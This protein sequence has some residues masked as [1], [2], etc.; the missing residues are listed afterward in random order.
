MKGGKGIKPDFRNCLETVCGLFDQSWLRKVSFSVFTITQKIFLQDIG[1]HKPA[2]PEGVQ[3]HSHDIQDFIPQGDSASAT[4][5]LLFICPTK[6]IFINDLFIYVPSLYLNNVA[7]PGH[8]KT[9]NFLNLHFTS[10][11]TQ[12][13]YLTN[14]YGMGENNKG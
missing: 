1:Y 10:N 14:Y 6:N 7:H 11:L 8:Y 12:I 4:L 5:M 9:R 3:Q 2:R 13:A